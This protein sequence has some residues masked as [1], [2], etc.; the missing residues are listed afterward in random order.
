MIIQFYK[1]KATALDI[2]LKNLKKKPISNQTYNLNKEA[3][4]SFTNKKKILFHKQRRNK[5]EKY[6]NYFLGSQIF[7]YKKNNNLNI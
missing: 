1:K 5:R 4:Y 7:M 3:N 6:L 2:Y